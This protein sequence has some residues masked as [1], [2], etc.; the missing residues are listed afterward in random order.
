MVSK[1][2]SCS[3]NSS[4]ILIAV[5]HTYM[6]YQ[7]GSTSTIIKTVFVLNNIMPSI[8]GGVSASHLTVKAVGLHIILQLN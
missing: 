2:K 8:L 6:E 1:S 3:E 5:P 7:C 4:P